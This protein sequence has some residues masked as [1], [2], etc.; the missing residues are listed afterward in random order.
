ML[1]TVGSK[2][3]KILYVINESKRI[4]REGEGGE[5]RNN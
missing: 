1:T 3:S 4:E 2:E 5:N